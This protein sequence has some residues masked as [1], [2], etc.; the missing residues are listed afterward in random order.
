[1]SFLVT[2]AERKYV[3]RRV[4]FQRHR[5]ASCHQV[6]FFLQGKALKEIH[7]ILKESLREHALSY[8]TIKNLVAKFKR[9]DF[10]TCDAPRPGRLKSD[11]P[12]DY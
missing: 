8:A 10:S 9:G 4:R 1:M 2:E 11:H 3:R 6:Y 7:D 5:D 12:G